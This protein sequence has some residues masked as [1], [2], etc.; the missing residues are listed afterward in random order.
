M[1]H[2]GGEKPGD[3]SYYSP[4]TVNLFGMF[5]YTTEVLDAYIYTEA[6]GNKGGNNV[7]S[8]IQKTLEKKGVFTEATNKGPGACLTLLFYTCCGQNK[9]TWY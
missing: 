9:T 1:P 4:L 5:D 8:L 3:T 7:V 6:E 2:F